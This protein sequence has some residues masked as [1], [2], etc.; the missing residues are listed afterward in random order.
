MLARPRGRSNGPAFLL[1]RIVGLAVVGTIVLL[2]SGSASGQ[3]RGEPATWVGVLKIVL[4]ALTLLLG[5]KQFRGRPRGDARR[6]LPKW[7]RAVDTFTPAR[8]IAIAA[9]LSGVNPKTC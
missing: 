3:R 4:G 7:M 5:V 8:S 2:F 6:D 9:S 1:G